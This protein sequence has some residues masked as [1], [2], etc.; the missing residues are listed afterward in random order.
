MSAIYHQSLV[1]QACG[2]SRIQ[3]D[4]IEDG[5][6]SAADVWQDLSEE[7]SDPR[8]LWRRTKPKELS[9]LFLRLHFPQLWLF[10]NTNY[11]SMRRNFLLRKQ[12]SIRKAVEKRAAQAQARG[13]VFE[14]PSSLD[15]PISP[16]DMTDAEEER[17]RVEAI[18][19]RCWDMLYEGE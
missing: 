10:V 16:I 7:V 6:G 17:C 14:V 3:R 15:K 8:L 1:N 11:D 4:Y 13:E 19:A 5:F 9:D 2:A 12:H 18:E